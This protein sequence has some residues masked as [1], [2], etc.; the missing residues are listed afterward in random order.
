MIR[1]EKL[2]KYYGGK[3]ALG[4]ISFEIGEGESVG[5]LGLNG[6][7]K[8]TALRILACDLRPSGGTVA[9]GDI[10]AVARP[11][12]LK[13]QI[14]FL[15]EHP[16]LYADMTV[17]DYL[18]FAG[19]LRG[20]ASADIGKRVD[21]AAAITQLDDVKGELIRHLSHGY[22]QRVGVA[23]AVI[24][25]PALLI[26]DEPTRGL[27]P[28]QIVEMRKMLRDLK[29]EHTVLISSHI[30]TEISETCD[31]LLVL[32]QG[33]IIASGSEDELSAG[34][35]E[36]TRIRVGVA[37]GEGA[38]PADAKLCIEGVDEVTSVGEPD[39]DD[40][41]YLFEVT[42]SS[43]ARAAIVRALVRA[44]FDVVHLDRSRRELEQIFLELVRGK[45]GADE[46]H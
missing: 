1:A 32:G 13:T 16:P 11:D 36:S 33:D 26:L 20:L 44:G 31:R 6:A 37:L 14:G 7:G 40:G 38:D 28:V 43:D 3:R 27:D 35:L 10:D 19:R 30:L 41:A 2:S 17:A 25:E 34:L 39:Y 5:F 18:T 15:P 12:K 45:G 24:H 23:Q 21:R 4:P 22:R 42:S 46:V 29:T 9:I 8:T